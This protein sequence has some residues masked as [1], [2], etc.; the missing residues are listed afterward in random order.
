MK[1]PT[2]QKKKC[3]DCIIAELD[4]PKFPFCNYHQGYNM[5]IMDLTTHLKEEIEKLDISRFNGEWINKKE[6]L[7]LL[8]DKK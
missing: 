3:Q 8:E 5:A 7:A 4:N 2:T 1:T 6:V